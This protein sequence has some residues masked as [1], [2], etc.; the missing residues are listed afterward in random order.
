LECPLFKC[1]HNLEAETSTKRRMALKRFNLLRLISIWNCQE[2]CVESIAIDFVCK[3][4]PIS[5]QILRY[6]TNGWYMEEIIFVIVKRLIHSKI[7]SPKNWCCSKSIILKIIKK[8]KKTS[9]I[10][11][12]T[13]FYLEKWYKKSANDEIYHNYIRSFE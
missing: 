13:N 6:L 11:N 9:Y 2:K 1:F 4:R 8:K 7:K 10:W 3:I 5:G 12:R